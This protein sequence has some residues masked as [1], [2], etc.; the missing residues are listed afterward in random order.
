MLHLRLLVL[1]G[2]GGLAGVGA[3]NSSPSDEAIKNAAVA[4]YADFARKDAKSL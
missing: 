3:V 2:I 1:I 4:P